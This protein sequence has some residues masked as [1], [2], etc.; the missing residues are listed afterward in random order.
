MEPINKAIAKMAQQIAMGPPLMAYEQSL[1]LIE[2]VEARL[3]KHGQRLP[4]S[5]YKALIV[6]LMLMVRGVESI[7]TESIKLFI[8]LATIAYLG[9]F[10]VGVL[11][12]EYSAVANGLLIL[13]IVVTSMMIIFPAPSTYCSEGINSKYVATVKD[14][15]THW[16][17]RSAKRVE[18]VAKNVKLFEERTQRRLVIFRWLLAASWAVV[19]LF[20]GELIKAVTATPPRAIDIAPL[21]PSI[22]LIGAIFI[23][24]EIYARGLDI[25]YR[26]IEF[27]C[28]ETIAQIDRCE[29]LEAEQKHGR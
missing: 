15:F 28:N 4:K 6:P 5:V 7:V 16:R 1:E 24:V 22:L 18:L 2:K 26:S 20:T 13:A 11:P 29:R 8:S 12:A 19:S 14:Q 27:G 21:L 3:A 10:A 23:F 9:I 17:E 25:V